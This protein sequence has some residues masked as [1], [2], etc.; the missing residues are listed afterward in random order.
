[1]YL[2][3][4]KQTGITIMTH[5]RLKLSTESVGKE[6]K[7]EAMVNWLKYWPG[8]HKVPGSYAH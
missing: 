1:M 7:E 2:W 5:V 8:N 6:Q 3:S 4:I